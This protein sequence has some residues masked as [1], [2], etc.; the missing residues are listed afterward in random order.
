[1][2]NY[3]HLSGRLGNQ[4]FQWAYCHTLE[5]IYG[6]APTPFVDKFHHNVNSLSFE[7]ISLP[8]CEH[9]E[10]G[11]KRN[12]LGFILMALDRFQNS[13]IFDFIY[14]KL[15]IMRSLDSCNLPEL[16][17]SQPRLVSGFFINRNSVEKHEEILFKEL[18]KHLLAVPIVDGLP[19]DYQV[20]HVR[21]GDFVTLDSTYGL[22]DLA[23][24]KSNLDTKLPLILCTDSPS[25]CADIIQELKPELVLS[26][27]NST[28]WQTIK[29]ISN[30]RHV[31]LS[32]ST[33]SWWGGFLAA[34]KQVTVIIPR[35]FYKDSEILNEV[36]EF[37][38]FTPKKAMFKGH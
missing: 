20:I 1:V 21:R 36:L 4:L 30:A 15:P 29:T 25:D 32:N 33:L 5:D 13:W 2:R 11:V 18:S 7:A 19:K 24:Y 10:S 9:I 22:V 23:F 6:E 26:P 8:E 12:S 35:P 31:V 14:R 37:R 27:S 34:K 3:F 17:R 16:P 28:A 38:L